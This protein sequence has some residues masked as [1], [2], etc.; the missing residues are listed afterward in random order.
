MTHEDGSVAIVGAEPRTLPQKLHRAAAREGCSVQH[1]GPG[2]KA[3]ARSAARAAQ[4]RGKAKPSAEEIAADAHLRHAAISAIVEEALRSEETDEEY[5][6]AF[7]NGGKINVKWLSEKVGFTV[8]A[9]ERD[10][11]QTTIEAKLDAEEG[12]GEEG[13]EGGEGGSAE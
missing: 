4:S 1:T 6:D 10:E 7:T 11:I 13:D 5:A 8:E 9:S 12:D 2:G 3:E